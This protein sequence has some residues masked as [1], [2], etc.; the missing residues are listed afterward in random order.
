MA[1][2]LAA[3]RAVSQGSGQW[4]V[5]WQGLGAALGLNYLAVLGVRMSS[6][7]SSNKGRL[8]KSV[9]SL[10]Q[11][12]PFRAAFCGLVPLLIASQIQLQGFKVA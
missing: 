4:A 7:D 6:M 1:A 12:S 10:L 11:T 3:D 8:V 2:D 5:Q 9:K